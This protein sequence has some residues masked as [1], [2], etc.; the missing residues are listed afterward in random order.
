MELETIF[1]FQAFFI[2]SKACIPGKIILVKGKSHNIKNYRDITMNL[3][4]K[5][6]S[7]LLQISR[8]MSVK[9][10]TQ[11]RIKSGAL[12]VSTSPHPSMSCQI[13]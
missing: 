2:Y 11:N 4:A 8:N 7:H 5:S 1:V 10:L 9:R 3:I 12:D 6:D 13:L